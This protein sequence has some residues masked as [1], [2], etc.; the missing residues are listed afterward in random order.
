[1]KTRFGVLLLVLSIASQAYAQTNENLYMAFTLNA[2][3]QPY[4]NLADCKNAS[5]VLL[6][7]GWSV[8]VPTAIYRW[9]YQE[10]ADAFFSTSSACGVVTLEIGTAATGTYDQSGWAASDIQIQ[11]YINEPSGTYP[12]NTLNPPTL[13]LQDVLTSTI[14]PTFQTS[15]SGTFTDPCQSNCQEDL[16]FCL[17]WQEV[18][19]TNV[20]GGTN[21]YAE[22]FGGALIRFDFNPPAQ[23]TLNAPKAG[24]TNLKLSWTAPG[25]DDLNGYVVSYSEQGLNDWHTKTVTD[26]NAT[27]YTLSGLQNDQPYDVRIAAV[28]KA[29]N[30]GEFSLPVTGTPIVINDFFETYKNDGGKENGGFC[31]VATAAY[32]SYQDSMVIP[33]RQF[34]DT[35]LSQSQVGRNFIAS[36]YQYGPR[37]ARA[38]RDSAFYRTVARGVLL[39]VVAVANAINYLGIGA[40]LLLAGALLV[41]WRG[42]RRWR[43]LRIPKSGAVVGTLL[44]FFVLAF[45]PIRA[46]AAEPQFQVQLRTGPTYPSEIDSESGLSPSQGDHEGHPFRDIFGRS[47]RW[48]FE[49]DTDYEIWRGFGVVTIGGSLG[50]VQYVGRGL[51][52]TTGAKSSDTAVLNLLP[53]RLTAAYAFDMMARW[54]KV[55]LVP[56]VGGGLS[57][58]IWWS[59]NG[60]GNVSTWTDADGKNFKA[61]GGVFGFH[62]LGGMKFLLNVID[63]E[64]AANLENA[65]GIVNTYLF[66]EYQASFINNFGRSSSINLSGNNIMFGMM[67]EF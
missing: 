64:A 11:P 23:P 50:F 43:R 34:R 29:Q 24:D 18:A 67:V 48:F 32:G 61:R 21:N 20:Y 39:P 9:Q 31:F 57:Y 66:V 15:C 59:T 55:P 63:P 17:R 19:S 41:A 6:T 22:Y 44:L 36:Y 65:V 42:V 25:D 58:Y 27:N 38:I 14:A 47:K 26:P 2:P 13:T 54:W 46:Q 56:Y 49:I 62:A 37:W 45:L 40:L 52:A 16:Y 35:A 12:D 33:L 30:E 10:G 4:V 8:T 5:N 3:S 7:L 28:D 1:M 53:L 60:V 51:I